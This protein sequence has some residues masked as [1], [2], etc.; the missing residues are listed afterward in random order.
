[1]SLLDF[2]IGI[3]IGSA[4]FF[5][6]GVVK[7]H[8]KGSQTQRIRQEWFL[9]RRKML[10]FYIEIDESEYEGTLKVSVFK[11]TPEQEARD[12]EKEGGG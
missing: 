6:L 9:A 11:R 8:R 7:A 10:P 1:M 4:I 12:L 2:L 5:A 3:A